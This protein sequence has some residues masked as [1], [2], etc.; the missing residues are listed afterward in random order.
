MIGSEVVVKYI[1]N[2]LHSVVDNDTTLKYE[3]VW[4]GN[5]ILGWSTKV[6]HWAA[7]HFSQDIIYLKPLC[8]AR[9][10]VIC[11]YQK[12]KFIKYYLKTYKMF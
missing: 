2:L 5:F 11:T 1:N 10:S 8:N 7:F 12:V 6:K 9:I 3:M 4:T